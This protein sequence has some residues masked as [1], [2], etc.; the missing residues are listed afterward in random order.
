MADKEKAGN[1]AVSFRA[2]GSGVISW[3][4]AGAG[5]YSDFTNGDDPACCSLEMVCCTVGDHGDGICFGYGMMKGYW[6]VASEV[7]TV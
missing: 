7:G 4:G 3:D 2:V 1:H 6:G 5:G